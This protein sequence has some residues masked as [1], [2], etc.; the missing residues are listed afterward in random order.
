VERIGQD[1]WQ[2]LY[3][4]AGVVVYILTTEKVTAVEH[5]V[6]SH[7]PINPVGYRSAIFLAIM[8]AWPIWILVQGSITERKGAF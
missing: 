8:F 7:L 6:E 1:F 5:T 3:V 4:L 2:P